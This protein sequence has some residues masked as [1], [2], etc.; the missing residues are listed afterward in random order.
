MKMRFKTIN[1]Y[2]EEKKNYMV[3]YLVFF[4]ENYIVGLNEDNLKV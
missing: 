1:D 2:I 4:N 3:I